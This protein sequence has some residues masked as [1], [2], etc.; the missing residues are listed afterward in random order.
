MRWVLFILAA[1]LVVALQATIFAPLGRAGS[2]IDLPLVFAV[3]VG[4]FSVR[5]R[6]L[7]AAWVIGMTTDF[8]CA[9]PLGLYAG[10]FVVVAAFAS[11]VGRRTY[12]RSLVLQCVVLCVAALFV[13]L[14]ALGVVATDRF[15]H[16]A[17]IALPRVALGGLVTALVGVPV[18][19]L[20]RRARFAVG[21]M[22]KA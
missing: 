22:D 4:L 12:V 10:L 2:L 7:V 19:Y 21:I 17:A 16:L 6:G 9:T 5:V 14:A 20:M 1:L 3:Y 8:F 11:A 15:A 18:M 13:R